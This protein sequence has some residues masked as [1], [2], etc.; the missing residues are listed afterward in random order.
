M[1]G[2]FGDDELPAHPGP[3]S[4]ATVLDI[5][6]R[7]G[8]EL[9]DRYTIAQK[10][11]RGGMGTVFRAA[12]AKGKRDV[13][14]KW[15]HLHL[16]DDADA[17]SRFHREARVVGALGHRNIVEALDFGR[18]PDG[19][20]FVVFELL[21]GEDLADLLDRGPLSPQDAVTIGLGVARALEAAH[22]HRVVH[23]DLKPANI[24]VRNDASGPDCVKVVDFGISKLIGETGE[25]TSTGVVVG[26]PMY[27]SPEQI[28]AKTVDHRTDIYSLGAVMYEML[29]GDAPIRGGSAAALAIKV[30][31]ESPTPLMKV[32]PE[33]SKPLAKMV[34]RLMAKR[35]EDRFATMREVRE[36][37]EAYVQAGPTAL[38]GSPVTG[39]SGVELEETAA[40]GGD[41]AVNGG[42]GAAPLGVP[43]SA[44]PSPAAIPPADPPSPARTAAA[45]ESTARYAA[46]SPERRPKTLAAFIV[47]LAI[48][49]LGA[50]VVVASLREGSSTPASSVSVSGEESLPGGGPSAP[51]SE[52]QPTEPAM[53]E[54]EPTEPSAVPEPEAAPETTAFQADPSA[55]PQDPEDPDEAPAETPR[56]TMRQRSRVRSSAMRTMEAAPTPMAPPAQM[57]PAP[58]AGSS[59]ML[60]NPFADG[61]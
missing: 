45:A 49:V 23:R 26:T 51:P 2:S 20:K 59:A 9:A 34:E 36:Q 50:A 13:A 41:A 16:A 55:V 39:F 6:P 22:N 48:G 10:L 42:A 32:R 60:W 44:A 46:F 25:L 35:P 53:P 5:D 4:A 1:K 14:V 7:V 54:L 29:A 15:L 47:A 18:A 21:E 37:L 19:S 30:V 38:A 24:F 33:L 12:D 57:E 28:T 58:A 17:V 61:Q 27:M 40:P 8:T 56:P 11:G 43:P 31:T 3:I 52:P